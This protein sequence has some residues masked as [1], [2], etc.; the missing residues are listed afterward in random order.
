MFS[1]NKEDQYV[2]CSNCGNFIKRKKVFCATYRY[3]GIILCKN[4]AKELYSNLK[5]FLNNKGDE[6]YEST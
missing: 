2:M 4:C 1:H 5:N 3:S 6:P